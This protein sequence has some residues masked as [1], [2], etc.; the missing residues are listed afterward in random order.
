MK[1]HILNIE[2]FDD[3]HSIKD[4]IDWGGSDRILIVWPTRKP[5]L[6]S[7]VDLVQIQRHSHSNGA[8]IALVV[9]N[10]L[11][12]QYASE[13][14]I[15]VFQSMR[16]ARG[17]PW[18]KGNFEKPKSPKTPPPKSS[19]AELLSKL[20]R[21]EKSGW[22]DKIPFRISFLVVG[23]ISALVIVGAVLPK[24]EVRLSPQI[25]S[26]DLDLTIITDPDLNGFT[27]TGG[28]EIKKHK[29]LVEG[30]DS[31]VPTSSITIPQNPAAGNVLFT[32]LTDREINIPMGTVVRTLGSNPVRFATTESGSIEA[33]PGAIL[34]V[35][36]EALNPGKD[37]NLPAGSLIV[38][39]GDLALNIAVDNPT[40]TR[41]GVERSSKAPSLDDYEILQSNLL[42]SLWLSALEETISALD[43]Q[44]I[45]IMIEPNS[46]NIVE[47]SFTPKEPQPASLL[48]LILTVEYELNYIS[49]TDL[50]KMSN[51]IMDSSTTDDFVFIPETLVINSQQNPQ[52]VS[53]QTFMMDISV[54]RNV[55]QTISREEVSSNIL[56]LSPRA[57][58]E[59]INNSYTL[60]DPALVTMSPTWWPLLPLLPIRISVITNN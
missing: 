7:K 36:V 26:Q 23:I 56:G 55:R 54:S 19:S 41:G 47:A 4:K 3:V 24:A 14:K 42:D 60:E 10:N 29:I 21:L 33:E 2:P 6:K 50:E 11:I 40:S 49:W 38:I 48:E 37:G 5:I 13:L 34:E 20:D 15:P 9:K 31:L 16:H 30:R 22:T 59:K 1:T 28:I 57:A 17:I 35:G 12:R 32:N 43:P 8:Q 52:Q 53:D 46:I 44:D 25:N 51:T 45:I 18:E 39:E 58:Q 27:L